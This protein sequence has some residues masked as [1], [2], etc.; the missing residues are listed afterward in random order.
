MFSIVGLLGL[1]LA[2]IFMPDPTVIDDIKERHAEG[3]PVPDLR[4]GP[5]IDDWSS[6]IAGH[7][8]GS[9]GGKFSPAYVELHRFV[10][11]PGIESDLR[12]LRAF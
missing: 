11:R 8:T 6:G 3:Q 12:M 10:R 4:H 7:A 9:M 2:A 5:P 1:A